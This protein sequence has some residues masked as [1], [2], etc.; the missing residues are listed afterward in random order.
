M[1]LKLFKK[2]VKLWMSHDILFDGLITLLYNYL[3]DILLG[4]K[5]L[6]M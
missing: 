2:N 6:D 3:Y 1:H 4:K 5:K